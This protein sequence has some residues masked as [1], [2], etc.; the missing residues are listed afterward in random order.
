MSAERVHDVRIVRDARIPV[1]SEGSRHGATLSADLYLPVTDH[2]VP[3]LVS[4]TPYR[5]DAL[6]GIGAA[7][8]L[9]WF[10]AHGYA[11][12]LV[13]FRG[14]GSSDG[15]A[16]PPF[17]PAEAD[18]GVAAV[19]WAARQPWCTGAVGMWGLS[20]GAVITLRTAARRP[21]HLGAIIPLLGMPD[22]ERDF[23]HP[24][25][26][27]G[28]LAPLGVWGLGTLRDQLL[29]PL[30][31]HRSS[32]EQRRWRERV[33]QAEPYLLD[34]YRHRPGHRVWRSRVVDA[35]AVTVPAFCVA[36]WR[37]LFCDGSL[38]AY[39]QLQGP[40]KLLVGPWM[41]TMPQES[42][43]DPVDF[44][45][46][47]LR[48]WDHWL[49]GIDNGVDREPPVTVRVQGHRPR[50]RSFDS[51]PPPG[52]PFSVAASAGPLAARLDPAVGSLSGLW[53]IPTSGFGL[54]GDQHEDDMAGLTV[55]GPPLERSLL[56]VG[57][58]AA[59]LAAAQ[60]C[61]FGR[62]VVKLTDVDPRGRSTL[63]TGGV[64]ADP[65]TAHRVVLDPTAYHLAAGHRLRV[66]V[67]D[68]AF[69]RLWPCGSESAPE[70]RVLR[71]TRLDLELPAVAGAEGRP[72]ILPVPG[73]G[74]GAELWI[75]DDPRWSV[76]RDPIHRATTVTMGGSLSARTPQREHLL[77]LET[78]LMATVEAAVPGA[79]RIHGS[80]TTTVRLGTGERIVVQVEL[81]LT[82]GAAVAAGTVHIDGVE[83]LNRHWHS[84]DEA[85]RRDRPAPVGD[86]PA[87]AAAQ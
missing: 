58:P 21:E 78:E 80:S 30:H 56:I 35:G 36:G 34:L 66:V 47:A 39:E 87:R 28:C 51:W 72:A 17:D 77:E 45:A 52:E 15:P 38:R 24:S 54:P 14:T 5:K 12:L 64:L 79:A 62:L 61:G 11:C 2:P 76:S 53:A 4:V 16:R 63:I 86:S 48:W 84:A 65:S 29:P 43:F 41:H 44:H 37:D 59:A 70:D 9:R 49:A 83:V 19:E 23:I 32:A 13:D 73:G 71:L 55:T 27:A 50:W 6:A 7:G 18:D 25:G 10:A 20:Y 33:E 75:G 69:P 26:A 85:S 82:E 31:A 42:P 8:S 67:S 74:D 3:A 57:R 46:L 81:R 60:V 40:R 1:P 22:P 68:G